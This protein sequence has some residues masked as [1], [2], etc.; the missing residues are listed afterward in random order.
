M[1]H[2]LIRRV[3]TLGHPR[4]LVVGDLILDRYVWGYA[5]RISQE[6][7]VPLLRADTREHRMGGAASVATMLRALEAEVVLMGGVG[8]D[9][10][11]RLVRSML[12]EA[13]VDIDLVV[14]LG[15]RP[16]TL[17]ER[18][19]GRAQDRHPQ[20]MI[21]VDYETRDPI[22]AEVEAS[23]IARLAVAVGSVDLVL[24]SDYDKGICT[25]GLLKALIAECRRQGVKVLADPI[26]GDDYAKYQGVN[27][28][29]PNRLEAQLATGM[30]ITTPGRCLGGWQSAGHPA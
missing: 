28:M 20:Q 17:K 15:D 11:A 5:E 23:L 9:D 29:T 16:T 25:P 3:E 24:I 22:G 13:G 12:S 1:A 19:I 27:T 10:E 14:E 6:A 4:I 7:P 30:T 8:R 18:Y 2:Y 21:R 26:R